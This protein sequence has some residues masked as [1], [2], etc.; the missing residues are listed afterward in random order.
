MRA[1]KLLAVILLAILLFSY[2]AKGFCG[3][4][5]TEIGE[6]C[7]DGADGDDTNGCGDDCLTIICGNGRVDSVIEEQCDDGAN[8]DDTDSCDDNC[9]IINCGNS[10]V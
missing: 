4:N 5:S 8:G 2:Q 9:L 7:D 10:R 6:E 3:D 1:Q